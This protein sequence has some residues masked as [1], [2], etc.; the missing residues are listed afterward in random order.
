GLRERASSP[1]SPQVPETEPEVDQASSASRSACSSIGPCNQSS[2]D[3]VC[4]GS[5]PAIQA[6]SAEPRPTGADRGAGSSAVSGSWVQSSSAS[7]SRGAGCCQ[8]SAAEA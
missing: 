2:R 4:E 3:E 6:D 8:S 1:R 5:G 7:A